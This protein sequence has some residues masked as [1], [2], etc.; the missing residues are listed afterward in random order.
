MTAI[1]IDKE[2][3]TWLLEAKPRI[4]ELSKSIGQQAP[5]EAEQ[6]RESWLNELADRLSNNLQEV[7]ELNQIAETYWLNWCAKKSAEY[8][9][10]PKSR[11]DLVKNIDSTERRVYKYTEAMLKTIETRTSLTQST[12]KF[13]R[14]V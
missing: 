10:A 13:Y 9:G 7:L 3:A 1:D 2:F 8:E 5:P 11:L 6:G 12:L 14:S 4:L